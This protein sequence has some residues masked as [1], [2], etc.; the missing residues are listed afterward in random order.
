MK[1]DDTPIEAKSANNEMETN[2]ALLTSLTNNNDEKGQSKAGFI[3]R[4]A[5][6]MPD[7]ETVIKSFETAVKHP[8]GLIHRISGLWSSKPASK[9]PVSTEERLTDFGPNEKET[10]DQ[11]AASI[12]D[13]GR[14]DFA[15]SGTSTSEEPNLDAH[16]E[17]LDIPAFLRRQAN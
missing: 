15:K 1:L 14:S 11:I 13:L 16:D 5:T 7:E 6:S 10:K 12:L 3:P 4:M 2:E 9:P 8:S 17:E